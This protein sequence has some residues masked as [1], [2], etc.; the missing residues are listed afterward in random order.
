MSAVITEIQNATMPKTI[1]LFLHNTHIE[2]KMAHLWKSQNVWKSG[3]NI[4][5]MLA[6]RS[7][8]IGIKKKFVKSWLVFSSIFDKKIKSVPIFFPQ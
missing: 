6:I 7:F 3:E 4:G 1:C 8:E 2:P 5:K